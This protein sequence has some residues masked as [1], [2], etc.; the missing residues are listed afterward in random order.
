MFLFIYYCINFFL[1]QK[2]GEQSANHPKI[3]SKGREGIQ[4]GGD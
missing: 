3:Y 1:N 2:G 4:D